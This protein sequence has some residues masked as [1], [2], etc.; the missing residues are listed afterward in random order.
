MR[1]IKPVSTRAKWWWHLR[2]LQ[3][4][5]THNLQDKDTTEVL[6]PEE[7]RNPPLVAPMPLVVDTGP[8]SLLS[9]PPPYI[10]DPTPT[11]TCPYSY[12][13]PQFPQPPR[14]YHTQVFSSAP[15][16]SLPVPFEE[17][18]TPKRVPKSRLKN[19]LVWLNEDVDKS[20]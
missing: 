9:M 5:S 3:Q 13:V 18:P 4:T 19:L 14:S 12:P 1:G 7:Y 8:S 20:A 10:L 2:D 11:T 16:A 6:P 17:P 15:V